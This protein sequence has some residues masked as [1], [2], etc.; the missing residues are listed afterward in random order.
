[1]TPPILKR[2]LF[3]WEQ[4]KLLGIGIF[5]LFLGGSLVFALQPEPPQPK[6]LYR[7]KG[8][9]AYRTPPPLFTSTG[10]ELQEQ[11]RLIPIDILFSPSVQ[12]RFQ[13]TLQLSNRQ[14]KEVIDR[15]LK[16]SASNPQNP[17][18]ILLEYKNAATPEEGVNRLVVL[19]NEMVE[20][21]RLVNTSQL[22][23]RIQALEQ[24]LSAVQR[25]LA[26]AEE[27][28]YRFISTEGTSL[29]AVQDGS[30]FTGITG[31]QQQQRQIKL[32]LEEIE[33]Q[34]DSIVEQLGLTPEQAYTVASLSADPVLANLQA[35]VTGIKSQIRNLEKDLRPDHPNMLTLRKELNALEASAEERADEILVTN[36]RYRPIP[37]KLREN[38]SLDPAR[39]QLA[40]SLIVLQTQREGI[41]RQLASVRETEED[42]RRQYEQFPDR[43]LQQARLVQEVETKRALYQTIVTALVDAQSAEAETTGTYTIAQTPSVETI[44][45]AFAP[46]NRLLIL[47]AGTGIG[48]VSAT[49]LIFLLALLDDRLH[50]PKELRELLISRDVPVLGSIPHIRSLNL[51]QE[52]AAIITNT[53]SSYLAFYEKA[54]SN[55]LR[56]SSPSTKVILVT[57]VHDNEGKSVNAY[58]LAITSANAGK[59]TLLLEA[60]LR[61]TSNAAWLNLEA[62]T[63]AYQE[64]LKYYS[65]PN[66]QDERLDQEAVRLV[67]SVP[68]L[69]MIPSPGKLKQVAAIIESDELR[70]LIEDARGRFDTVIIDSPSLSKCND[71]LLL[72]SLTDG[73]VLITRPGIC[74]GSMLGDTIDQLTE[75]EIPVLGAII[76]N[77]EKI[78][79]NSSLNDSED[80]ASKQDNLGIGFNR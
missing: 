36:P 59:R 67:P 47:V 8:Q 58:N 66:Y 31:A 26:A 39:Q 46:T 18:F 48:L 64:P 56:Y 9:L 63:N 3:S 71:A 12:E 65:K 62:D 72:E 78:G 27:A 51:N 17:Q 4:N 10:A 69:S 33:G 53:E 45:T 13:E 7:I 76:N 77:P 68:N 22:R 73:V 34:I 32:F 54:R 55:L 11:G 15:K 16:L 24:R 49:G 29:L 75:I 30:L 37:G 79:L 50:T 43:Q 23:N 5:L 57:S 60:D 14:M 20:Q 35:Q 2:F 28:F 21:S 42:L 52:E 38:S 6:T 19:M 80:V 40:N 25:E 74:R 61:S 44:N 41:L 1:M 70:L